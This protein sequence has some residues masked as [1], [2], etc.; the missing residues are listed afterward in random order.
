[1]NTSKE[2]AAKVVNEILKDDELKLKLAIALSSLLTSRKE[3]NE[4]LA[5]IKALREETRSVWI[6]LTRL[7]EDFN[8]RFDAH[9]REMTEL[10]KETNELRKETIR[11]REEMLRLR[12]DFN[13]RFVAHERE[14]A[15]LRKETT[16]LHE[17]LARLREDFNKRFEAHERE[18]IK[19]REE[20][21]ELRREMIKLREDFNKGMM[22][23]KIT[24]NALGARWGIMSEETFRNALRGILEKRFNVKIKKWE[25]YDEKG[26][27][28]NIPSIIDIDVAI[29]NKI[30]TLIE[31]KS[32]VRKSDVATLLRKAELYKE[33]TGKEPKLIIVTPFIE[34]KAKEFALAKKITVYTS[35]YPE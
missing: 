23:L 18:M 33:V 20:T 34:D 13:K 14:M 6:E 17:E 25:A 28:F 7:R 30:D 10:R 19:L 5:E 32:H 4:L 15:E 12:E 24:V 31:I 35:V 1:M 2:I 22:E 27:V 8:K 9:E 26:I 11:L 3:T 29:I 21:N 16:K